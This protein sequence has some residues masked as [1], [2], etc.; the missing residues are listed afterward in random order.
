M[1]EITREQESAIARLAIDH[2]SV[3]VS[4]QEAG[5]VK[6]EAGGRRYVL[7]GDGNYVSEPV[8]HAYMQLPVALLRRMLGDDVMDA[9]LAA[10]VSRPYPD[11][12]LGNAIALDVQARI[13]E[14][15]ATS[16]AVREGNIS[17]VM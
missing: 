15:L 3:A 10:V 14:L 13:L 6:V 9:A 7:D 11:H 4:P 17:E 16:D 2:P 12:A 1:H 5:T 8:E